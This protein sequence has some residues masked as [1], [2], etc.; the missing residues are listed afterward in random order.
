MILLMTEERARSLGY[1]GGCKLPQLF[2][3]SKVRIFQ[4]RT[5]VAG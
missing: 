2:N 1:K 5:A 3:S 4:S